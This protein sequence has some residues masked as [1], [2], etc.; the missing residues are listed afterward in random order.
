[1]SARDKFAFYY[2]YTGVLY[3]I[4]RILVPADLYYLLFTQLAFSISIWQLPV[5]EGTDF[6]HK[7]ASQG[8]PAYLA[9]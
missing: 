1:M 2:E 5:Y 7:N 8:T 6:I 4:T 3:I 9:F